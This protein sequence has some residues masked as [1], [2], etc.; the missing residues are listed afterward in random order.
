MR[1]FERLLV[2]SEAELAQ[3]FAKFPIDRHGQVEPTL[4]ASSG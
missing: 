2:S 1:P 3:T 4:P